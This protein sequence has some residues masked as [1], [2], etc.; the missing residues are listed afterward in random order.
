MISVSTILSVPMFGTGAKLIARM[1]E[2]TSARERKPPMLSTGSV[3]SFTCA[4]TSF[5][6]ITI[7]TTASGRVRRNTEP[8]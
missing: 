5:H 8:Q 1:S 3:P 7:A 6:A 4:G 2:P